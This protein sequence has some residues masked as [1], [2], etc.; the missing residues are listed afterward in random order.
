MGRQIAEEVFADF[1]AFV[2]KVRTK[3]TETEIVFI[4]WSPT[5]SRWKQKDKEKTLN[6][7]VGNY[8]RQTPHVKYI[9]T[10]D[11]VL[12]ADGKPRPELFLADQ[13]HF[14]AAGY[15]LLAER[16]RPFLPK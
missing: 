1:K 9:E 6:D 14:N 7:L 12:G 11:M 2:A 15:E 10:S 13:L 16:V 8:A 3:L 4:S 5:P